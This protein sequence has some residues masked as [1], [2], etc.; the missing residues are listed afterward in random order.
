MLE[1]ESKCVSQSLRV[2]ARVCAVEPESKRES[3]CLNCG[4]R[5]NAVEPESMLW[6]QSLCGGARVYVE[7]PDSSCFSLDFGVSSGPVGTNPDFFDRQVKG[8]ILNLSCSWNFFVGT[9]RHA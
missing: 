7:K 9:L 1:P 2:G 3:Q 6:S 5:V 8:T 4:A